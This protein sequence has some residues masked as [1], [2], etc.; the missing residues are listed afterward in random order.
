MDMVQALEEVLH[1]VCVR[2]SRKAEVTWESNSK[3]AGYW[4]V[5]YQREGV[6]CAVTAGEGGEGNT[7]VMR[8]VYTGKKVEGNDMQK[9]GWEEEEVT[10]TEESLSECDWAR[11]ENMIASV[12]GLAD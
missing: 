2:G 8:W 7:V 4:K 6:R 5:Q 12:V 3:S 1:N 10:H 11:E 9:K